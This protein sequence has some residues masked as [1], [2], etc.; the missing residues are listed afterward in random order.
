[1]AGEDGPN[2]ILEVHA[3]VIVLQII[4]VEGR[5]S[6]IATG[7]FLVRRFKETWP[8]KVITFRESVAT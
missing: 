7:V 2:E 6:R 3:Y 4:K 1:M 5:S 8:R